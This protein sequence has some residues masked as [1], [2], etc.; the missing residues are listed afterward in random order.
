MLETQINSL[1]LDVHDSTVAV[2]PGTPRIGNILMEYPGG[3]VLFDDIADFAGDASTYQNVALYLQNFEEAAD[4][5]SSVSATA[6][7]IEGLSFPTLPYDSTNPY[8]PVHPLGLFTFWTPD[9]I[10][11]QLVSYS[12]TA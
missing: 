11:A 8:A 12:V 4:M 1:A 10:Q 7:S 5:T 3:R 6:A 9:G 2:Q